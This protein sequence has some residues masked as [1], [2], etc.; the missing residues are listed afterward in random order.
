[1]EETTS[2]EVTT[3]TTLDETTSTEVTTTTTIDETTEETTTTTMDETTE[4]TTTTTME[5]TEDNPYK[6]FDFSHVPC[7]HQAAL[8]E[9]LR[10]IAAGDKD[11]YF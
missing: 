6:D 7:K 8:K 3:T 4:V 11:I 1:M 9:F 2:T 5:E 10:K